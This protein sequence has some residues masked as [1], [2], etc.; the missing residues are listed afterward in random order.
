MYGKKKNVMGHIP[1]LL[2]QATNKLE[3]TNWENALVTKETKTALFEIPLPDNLTRKLILYPVEVSRSG[4]KKSK[5]AT[6]GHGLTMKTMSLK[7]LPIYL[8]IDVLHSDYR[9]L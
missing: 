6:A 7:V 3:L 4:P 9:N 1:V 2:K 5:F 8:S